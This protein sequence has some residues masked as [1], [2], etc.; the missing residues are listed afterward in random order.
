MVSVDWSVTGGVLFGKQKT[1][2]TGDEQAT[3][4]LV[5]NYLYQPDDPALL[6]P[7]EPI[8]I[9][10]EKSI[11]VPVVDLSLGLSYEIQ[12]IKVGAGYRWERYFN[13]LDTGYDQAKKADRTIDGPYFKVSVG[14]GG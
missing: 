2:V 5:S 4:F 8:D 7:P 13:V 6:N 10:R 11:S 3:Y 14:F 12:R 1:S 9:R